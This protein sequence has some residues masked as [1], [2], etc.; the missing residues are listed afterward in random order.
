MLINLYNGK[1]YSDIAKNYKI[2]TDYLQWIKQNLTQDFTE[3]YLLNLF[4]KVIQNIIGDLRTRLVEEA[5]REE[6]IQI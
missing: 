3:Q 5:S 6:L 2:V 1:D 4:K